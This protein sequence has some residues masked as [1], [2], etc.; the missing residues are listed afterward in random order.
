MFYW[1]TGLLAGCFVDLCLNLA[2]APEHF[3]L[4]TTARRLLVASWLHG[5]RS[6][7]HAAGADHRRS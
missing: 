3:S 4:L 5:G 1:Q 6:E 7:G 2:K